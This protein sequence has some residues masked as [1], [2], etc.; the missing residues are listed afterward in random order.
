VT[1]RDN[2]WKWWRNAPGF[3]QRFT[4]TIRDDGRTIVGKGQLSKDGASWRAISSSPTRASSDGAE[5]RRWEPC[6]LTAVAP[7]GG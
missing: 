3:T 4:G 2:T 1:L 5:R 6:R 7:G